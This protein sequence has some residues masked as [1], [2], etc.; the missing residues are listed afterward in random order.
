MNIAKIGEIV[1][2]AAKVADKACSTGGNILGMAGVNFPCPKCHKSALVSEYSGNLVD[3][4]IQCPN[5]KAMIA[6]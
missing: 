2:A 6:K 4:Q 1:D 5:C 3:G